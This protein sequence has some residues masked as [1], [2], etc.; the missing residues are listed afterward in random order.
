MPL[1][2]VSTVQCWVAKCYPWWQKRSS[3]GS[4]IFKEILYL[5]FWYEVFL[6]IINMNW[7]ETAYEILSI[8]FC[9]KVAK[10]LNCTLFHG[11]D[12]P[13]RTGCPSCHGITPWGLHTVQAGR[14]GAAAF[15]SRWQLGLAKGICLQPPFYLYSSLRNPRTSPHNDLFVWFAYKISLQ[16]SNA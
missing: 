16:G 5:N 2:V 15:H 14:K 6:F 1:F 3:F 13:W 4:F 10:S 9:K 8:Y 11:A 7:M 12:S